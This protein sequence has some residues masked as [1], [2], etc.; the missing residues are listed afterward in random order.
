MLSLDLVVCIAITV[1][2]SGK[3]H[4]L[5]CLSSCLIFSCSK[6]DAFPEHASPLVFQYTDTHTN[7]ATKGWRKRLSFLIYLKSLFL[8]AEGEVRQQS[9]ANI[10]PC[11]RCGG[12]L[13]IPPP[14][15]QCCFTPSLPQLW[16]VSVCTDLFS[17]LDWLWVGSTPPPP[18]LG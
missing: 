17:V 2:S 1:L 11:R 15:Q 12:R 16:C 14:S 9:E 4:H 10:M 7:R 18:S 3:F 13:P 5:I 6:P 8:E